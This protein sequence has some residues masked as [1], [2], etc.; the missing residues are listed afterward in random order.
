MAR[1]FNVFIP[2]GVLTLLVSEVLLLACS[3]VL[4]CNIVL[5]ADPSVFLFY[6]GGIARISVVVI[7]I[8]LGLHFNDLYTQINVRSGIVLLQQ[9][10]LVVGSAFLMQ[11]LVGYV[12][13]DM[14]LP[15]RVMLVGSAIATFAIL[16]WRLLYSRYAA[17]VVGVQRLLFFGGSPLLQQIGEHIVEHPELGTAVAGYVMDDAAPRKL[18]GGPYLGVTAKL[19]EIVQSVRPDCIIVGF[20]ERRNFLPVDELLELRLS[21]FPIEEETTT[22]EKIL[23]RICLSQLRPSQLIYSGELGPQPRLVFYQRLV[24]TALALIG[25][26]TAWPFILLT[27][28]A[29]RLTSAG[30]ILYRQTRVGL[31]GAHFQ[32]YKF[33]SMRVGAEDNTGA[34]WA[35]R[36]DPRVTPI[37]NF[38]RR[39]RLDEL[40]QIFNVLRGEMS[41]VGPR[42]ERPEFVKDFCEQI[43]YYR[44]RHCVR[45]GITGWAQVNYKYGDTL[46]DTKIKL[47]Y[48]LYYIKNLSQGL[49]TYII[50]H[51]LKTIVLSRGGQ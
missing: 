7:S 11:A 9:L 2:L 51:T 16:T 43:P 49:D 6:E 3:Y 21:G 12:R 25:L 46:E 35:Q 5:E 26:L 17:N 33:R 20:S 27:A 32:V 45:P 19:R 1:F 34:V 24:H 4:A 13:A 31:N 14:R 30:P 48:D 18:P 8:L 39:T 28:L 37:G 15:I 40:P 29:V 41:L 38:L 44:Q 42:P 22:Y 50:F 36:N 23:G 47:E 10:S